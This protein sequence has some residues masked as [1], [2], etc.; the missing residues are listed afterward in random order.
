MS[1]GSINSNQ[2]RLN[3]RSRP[4]DSRVFKNVPTAKQG[5]ENFIKTN[6]KKKSLVE[7]TEEQNELKQRGTFG[8]F[9][10]MFFYIVFAIL[11]GLI[12]VQAIITFIR[13]AP[14]L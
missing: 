5:Q 13:D 1:H 11:V 2:T 14:F 7:Y 8:R 3:N 9:M 6:V 4:K 12:F 10:R